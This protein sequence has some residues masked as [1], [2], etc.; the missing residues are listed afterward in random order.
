M[1][2]SLSALAGDDQRLGRLFTILGIG[3]LIASLIAGILGIVVVG[4]LTRSA[5]QSLAVTVKAVETADE[6]VALAADTL[7]IVSE[8]FDTLVPSAE[9]AATTFEDA[10]TV[11]ADSAVV[12]AVDVPDALDA[13]VDAMPAIETTAEIIDNALRVLSFVGVDYEPEVPFDEA[14]AE[15]TAAI[16]ELPEQLRAQAVPLA[17]LAADF[18]EFG[19]ATVEIADD[20]ADLQNQLDEAEL[21]LDSYAATAGDATVIVNEIRDDLQWQRWLMVLV[22][23]LVT[24]AFAVTQ[25]VPILLGRRFTDRAA[26]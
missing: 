15:L 18:E 12:V 24:G 19:I 25:T 13:V 8:S 7:G 5:D 23:V 26:K 2:E 14:V 9:L 16:D 10:A 6:T 22:V 21:L 3:G 11:I 17:S 20:L 1:S 4:A